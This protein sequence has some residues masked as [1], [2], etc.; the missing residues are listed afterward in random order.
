MRNGVGF[1]LGLTALISGCSSSIS[2][3]ERQPMREEIDASTAQIVNRLS[4]LY[5]NWLSSSPMRKGMPLF[6]CLTSKCP[7]LAPEWVLALFIIKQMA[8]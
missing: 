7:F 3:E 5:Q 4:E 8:Q 1:V 2:V 6:L